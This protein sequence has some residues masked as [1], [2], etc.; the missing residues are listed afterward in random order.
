[1][2]GKAIPP[3]FTKRR[4]WS[5][6]FFA[7]ASFL[8][9]DKFCRN[10]LMAICSMNTVLAATSRRGL[11]RQCRGRPGACFAGPGSAG[12]IPGRARLADGNRSIPRGRF[13]AD[14]STRTASIPIV[15]LK[16]PR[17]TTKALIRGLA[18][19]AH[20]R[21]RFCMS[22]FS[23]SPW[24]KVLRRSPTSPILLKGEA[25][26]CG[27]FGSVILEADFGAKS[28]RCVSR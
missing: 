28:N 27:S 2:I 1:L 8:F 10:Q 11:P 7:V 25:A 21:P 9:T 3:R 12:R 22:T 23:A 26:G 16:R 17:R 24:N 5:N 6:S 15:D 18:V 14:A 4:R 20:Q 13:A 19:R